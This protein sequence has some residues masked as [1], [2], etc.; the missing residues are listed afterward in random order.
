MDS[1]SLDRL[2]SAAGRALLDRLSLERPDDTTLVTTVSSLRSEGHD[3]SLV[4]DVLTQLGLRRRAVKKFG[5]FASAMRFTE[6]GLE[7]ATR[8]QV[9]AHH[10]GR[11]RAA[12]I[13]SVADLGC[14]IGGD[15]LA[16]ASLGITTLAVERD[17]LTARVAASNLAAYP[18]AT[19]L[20]ADVADALD[21]TVPDLAA[22]I[23]AVDALW[24]DP[25]R[26]DGTRKLRDPADWSPAL[27]A[28]FARAARQPIGVKLSPAMDRALVPE[29]TF[30]PERA[31]AQWVSVHRELLELTVWTGALA[32]DGV[33]RSALVIDDDGAHELTAPADSADPEP[34]PI[35]AFL[36]EPDPAVIRARQIGQ[37]ARTLDAGLLAPQIAYLT[38]DEPTA[39]PFGRTFTVRDVLPVREKPLAQALRARGIGTLEIKVR[40]LD[41]DPAA[42]RNR[43]KLRGDDAATLILTRAG[44]RRVAVLADRLAA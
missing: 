20:C 22:A 36:I 11:L 29:G 2:D 24:F 27:D 12:G 14:G 19:V 18:E 35:G 32:R 16:F 38:S 26:R 4:A 3:P 1:A 43:L 15:S 31:E 5:A 30:V 21:G 34:R 9:A 42:F 37:L 25:A 7:Q 40:G 8:L 23:D 41:V 17:E 33:A 44:E 6:A 10:A 39:T 28:I 13:R